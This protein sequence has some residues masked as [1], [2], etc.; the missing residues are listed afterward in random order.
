MSVEK[1]HARSVYDSRGNPTVE[2]EITTEGG[3]FRAIVPSGAS[4]GVSEAVEVRDGDKS[5]WGGKG[6]LKAVANVN[7]VLGPV[8]VKSGL[9]VTDQEAVDD[10][11]IKTDG[12]PNKA[13]LGANAIL[14]ISLAVARA[15]AHEKGVPLY[16]HL[17]DL[18][19]GRHDANKPFVLPVP[20]MNVLNGGEHAGGLLPFQEFMIGAI[21]APSFF[22]AVRW[23]SEVYHILKKLAVEKYGPS[24]GNVGDEGGV[25]PNLTTAEEA[26]DLIVEA[27]NKA[28]YEGK[29]K[30]AMDAASSQFCKESKYDLDFKKQEDSSP[31]EWLSGE[32]LAQKYHELVDQYP[33]AFLEDPFGENDWESW[34]KFLAGGVKVPVVA[35][36]LVCTNTK[37]IARAVKEKAADTLLLKVNQIGSLTE[38]F[39][40]AREAY[41][42]G[43]G[44]L[45]SH[46][47]GETEDSFI[48][49]LVVA[50]G[51]GEIKSGAPCRSERL[52]KYNQILRIEEELGSK[53]IFAA[54]D[55]HDSYKHHQ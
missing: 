50:L 51:T 45:V 6:V 10:L 8:L 36:D 32:K 13:K 11:L 29:V 48:A 24:A 33:L 20:F 2:V 37:L 34:S 55:F 1:V 9:K 25:A 4:T 46:R 12:T 38:S 52:A 28:G 39:A 14:G 26:L 7:D 30:I 22:E 42:A 16:V 43:W 19:E 31:S 40:A 54:K 23:N 17:R 5:H 44:I 49:D 53:A 41:D 35:D 3:L 21:G 15:G 18:F 27:I 47:S